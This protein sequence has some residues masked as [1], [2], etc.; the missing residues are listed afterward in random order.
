MLITSLLSQ[1]FYDAVKLPQSRFSL[2]FP[3]RCLCMDYKNEMITSSAVL[4]GHYDRGTAGSKEKVPSFI[5]SVQTMNTERVWE[6]YIS[7][8]KVKLLSQDH[9]A[10]RRR[11]INI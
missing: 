1:E 11:L 3:L 6:V 10:Y 7:S 2:V 9:I 5:P 4:S 8:I